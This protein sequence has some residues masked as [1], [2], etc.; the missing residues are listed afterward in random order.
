M[1]TSTISDLKVIDSFTTQIK[2]V[3]YLVFYLQISFLP[4]R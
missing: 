1:S 3:M 2:P 4:Y